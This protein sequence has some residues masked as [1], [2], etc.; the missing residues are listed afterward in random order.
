MEQF[1]TDAI[2]PALSGLLFLTQAVYYAKVYNQIH[3][4][5]K[6]KTA[7]PAETPPLSVILVAKD[8]A[9]ELKQHL[10]SILEQDYPKFEV[11]VVHDRT[12]DDCDDVLK[13]L[14]DKYSNLYHTFIP[15]SARHISHKKL[16]ITVGIK[17]SRHEWLVFTE[18]DCWPQS[19]QWL[20]KMAENFTP[21]TE[22]VLGYCNYEKAPGWFNKQITF[23]TLL[24][25]MR[26]LGMALAGHPYTGTG[27]NLA[28]RKSLYYTR[29]GFASHLELQRGEDDLFIN[30]NANRNNVRVETS[31]ESILR[32]ATPKFKRLWREEKISYIATGS[33]FQGITRYLMGAETCS[34]LLFYAA[35]ITTVVF[36]LLYHRWIALC[37]GLLLWVVRFVMQLIVFEKTTH[38]LHERKFRLLLPLFDLLQPAWNFRLKIQKNLRKKSNSPWK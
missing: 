35:A 24:N 15:D 1:I 34:R 26:Y 17:A 13:L 18:P 5:G 33:F 11:I 6:K 14:E 37:I 21:D 2:L 10:P 30:E 32:T 19:N 4:H 31:P 28:Y 38:D 22:I 29:N 25:A 20:R 9:H 7:A 36:A 23:D 12:S 3:R 8:T 16:G 27:R